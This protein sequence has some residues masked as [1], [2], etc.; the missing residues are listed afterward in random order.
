MLMPSV[1]AV[2]GSAA[3]AR[4]AIPSCVRVRTRWTAATTTTAS[5]KATTLTI[6]TVIPA[7]VSPVR[8]HGAS[9][10][11]GLVP[12]PKVNIPCPI[13]S[14]PKVATSDASGGV[15]GQALQQQSLGEGGDE[16][17]HRADHQERQQRIDR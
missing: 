11:S 15:T 17:D 4:S 7:M 12:N 8:P 5:T 3:A 6:W 16:E 14:R 13:S 2:A 10:D 1:L 9:R